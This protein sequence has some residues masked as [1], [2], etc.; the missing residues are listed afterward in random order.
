MLKLKVNN[1]E[2]EIEEGLTVLQACEN[3]GVEIPRF[4]YHENLTI[5]GNC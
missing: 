4:F 3:A 2:V 1:I 5:E